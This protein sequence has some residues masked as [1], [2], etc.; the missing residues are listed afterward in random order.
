MLEQADRRIVEPRRPARTE[1]QN[2]DAGA[3]AQDRDERRALGRNR[4]SRRFQ[5]AEPVKAFAWPIHPAGF[6]APELLELARLQGWTLKPA[7]LR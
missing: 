3:A 7:R 4:V 6:S 1:R 5:R 2:P